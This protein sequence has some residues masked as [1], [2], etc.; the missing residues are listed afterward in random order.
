MYVSEVYC[1][2]SQLY[3]L[4]FGVLVTDTLSFTFLA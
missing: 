2:T 1:A 3:E 4:L